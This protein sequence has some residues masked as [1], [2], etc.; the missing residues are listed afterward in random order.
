ML[1]DPNVG[2]LNWLLGLVG[3]PPI[4][5]LGDPAWA[6]P[7]LV[8]I[9]I[10][11]SLGFTM[12]IWL[13]GM[14]A[15]PKEL[16]DAAKVDGANSIQSFRHLTVPMLA[17]TTAF[18]LITGVIGSF[19]VFTPIYVMTKGGPLDST[20]VAVYRIFERAFDELKMGYASAMAWVLFLVIFVL[21]ALQFWFIRRRGTFNA[22]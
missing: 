18:L 15:I 11:K 8:I 5:W 9:T 16:Y 6:M 4:N 20:D 17:P 22:S 10:W 2:V 7:A 1:L 19:Q 3:L 12:V 14:Q 21:T 13:A